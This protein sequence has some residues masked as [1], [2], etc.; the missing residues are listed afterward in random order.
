[1]PL[2]SSLPCGHPEISQEENCATILKHENFPPRCPRQK[3]PLPQP[4]IFS[5]DL[6]PKPFVARSWTREIWRSAETWACYAIGPECRST[7]VPPQHLQSNWGVGG[8]AGGPDTGDNSREGRG[9][10]GPDGW[11]EAKPPGPPGGSLWA[12]AT[13]HLSGMEMEP[14]ATSHSNRMAAGRSGLALWY[15]ITVENRREAS[16]RRPK[17][18]CCSVNPSNTCKG[19][20]CGCST[21]TCNVD[22]TRPHC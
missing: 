12:N 2:G 7:P 6:G 1:M 5:G 10:P 20:G 13:W 19:M 21:E 17:S 15:P 9:A 16:N 8:W 11:W 4:C 14:K 18:H 22:H 3:Y